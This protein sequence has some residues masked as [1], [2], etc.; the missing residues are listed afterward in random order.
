MKPQRV[1]GT[2]TGERRTGF[3]FSWHE[4]W[5]QLRGG[6]NW[7]TITPIHVELEWEK[8][9]DRVEAA[10]TLLGIGVKISYVYS[11]RF[12]RE[13]DAAMQDIQ[14]HPDVAVKLSDLLDDKAAAAELLGQIASVR[15]PLERD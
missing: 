8:Y 3:F 7:Y 1:A 10:F 6:C 5:S 11:D 15:P 13:M 12:A 14:L 2:G 4:E 9:T